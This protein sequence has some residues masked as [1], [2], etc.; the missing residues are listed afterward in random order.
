MGGNWKLNPTTV[1]AANNLA[2]GVANLVKDIDT[3]DAVV[4]PPF[5]LLGL[6]KSK[7]AGTNVKVRFIRSC[8]VFLMYS[9]SWEH[10]MCS[11][12]LQE[13]TQEQYLL[14]Y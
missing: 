5:P 7:I 9:I 2:T 8:K 4:F 14:I 3:V 13:H 6:V 10:K 11:M 12:N 1:E